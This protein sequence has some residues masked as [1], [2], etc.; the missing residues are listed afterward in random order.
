MDIRPIYGHDYKAA[1]AAKNLEK[2][3]LVDRTDLYNSFQDMTNELISICRFTLSAITS[4]TTIST[5]HCLILMVW[6]SSVSL[7]NLSNDDGD[8]TENVISKYKFASL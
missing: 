1:C 2:L 4:N 7:G 5:T 3:L 8:G 6:P